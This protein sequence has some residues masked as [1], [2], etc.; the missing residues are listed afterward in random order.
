MCSGWG[1]GGV[2]VNHQTQVNNYVAVVVYGPRWYVAK[3]L[4]IRSK[5]YNV[6]YMSPCRGKWKW[7]QTETGYVLF[8]DVITGISAPRKIGTSALLEVHLEDLE[9]VVSK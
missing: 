5:G 4:K 3:V 6:S 8:K 1:W 7:D 9:Q 2:T